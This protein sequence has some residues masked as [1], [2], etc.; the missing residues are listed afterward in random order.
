VSQPLAG[1][2]T[3]NAKAASRTFPGRSKYRETAGSWTAYGQFADIRGAVIVTDMDNHGQLAVADAG[4][5]WTRT[6][7]VAD[8]TRPRIGHGLPVALDWLWTGTNH[9]HCN[10]S[11]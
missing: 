10:C 4:T 11:G 9:G 8:W 7:P 5:D 6:C 1:H 2:H 3:G